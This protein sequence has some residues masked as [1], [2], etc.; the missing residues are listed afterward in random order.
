M[1]N[2][3]RL[4][5]VDDDRRIRDLLTKYLKDQG[6]EVVSAEDAAKAEAHLNKTSF[7]AMV[8]DIMMPG[9][10]GLAFA[11]RLRASGEK[12]LAHLPIVMLTALGEVDDRIAGLEQG[13][14]DYLSKPFE[15]RELVLRIE[16]LIIRVNQAP[17]DR[18]GADFVKLGEFI[19]DMNTRRLTRGNEIIYL[20]STESDLLDTFAHEQRKPLSRDD[21][22]TRLGVT[23][24]PRTVDVQITR[25]RK[26]IEDDPAKPRFLK[27]VRHKGY[28]LWPD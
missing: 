24:S 16:K 21:L 6:Y 13:A 26:K 22:A 18:S 25:L 12:R 10:N 2:V 17:L 8:L 7:D 5:V 1:T 4:L 15:P 14:D 9:E 20:T 27:T 11:A 19:Y 23:L 28:G 3:K